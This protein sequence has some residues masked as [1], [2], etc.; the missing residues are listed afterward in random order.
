M[1]QE[2]GKC[3]CGELLPIPDLFDD[4][5]QCSCGAWWICTRIVWRGESDRGFWV[6]EH[7]WTQLTQRA[8]QP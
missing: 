5:H 2:Q 4:D 6:A 3:Y 7:T 8:R 1:T